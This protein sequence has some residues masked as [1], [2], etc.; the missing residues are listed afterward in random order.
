MDAVLPKIFVCG[1]HCKTRVPR[2]PVPP[3]WEYA[4]RSIGIAPL[5]QSL[6][7]VFVQTVYGS[8]V[9]VQ[10]IIDKSTRRPGQIRVGVLDS[11]Q[12]PVYFR[13]VVIRAYGTSD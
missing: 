2:V 6:L 4:I 8:G 5:I 1:L 9:E 3:A 13:L 10:K 12:F 11:R 7:P